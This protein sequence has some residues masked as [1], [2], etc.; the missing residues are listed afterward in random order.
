MIMSVMAFVDDFPGNI[1][2]KLSKNTEAENI[3]ELFSQYYMHKDV[4]N[5]SNIQV[6]CFKLL[7]LYFNIHL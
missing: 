6:V 2:S 3:E 1:L 7:Y 4:C 5:R